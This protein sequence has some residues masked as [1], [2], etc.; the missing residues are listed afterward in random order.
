MSQVRHRAGDGAATPACRRGLPAVRRLLGALALALLLAGCAAAPAEQELAGAGSPTPQG[1]VESFLAVLNE[2]L[3]DPRLGQA[4]ARRAWSERL[5]SY[6]APSERADQRAAMGEMLAAFAD[7]ASRPAFGS[8]VQ[9]EVTYSG[10]EI[11]SRSGDEALV[12]VVDGVFALRWL[13]DGGEVLRERSG[14]LTEVIGQASGG[15]P[16][17]RVGGSWFMTEG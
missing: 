4:E 11:I 7:S 14:G 12:R 15:L 10:I 2:A 3:A 6:F 8:R 1:A 5:A 13:D 9:L 17:L 16:V